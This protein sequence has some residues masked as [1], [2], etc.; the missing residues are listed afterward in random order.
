M[1]VLSSDAQAANRSE[2]SAMAFSRARVSIST[3]TTLHM[4]KKMVKK[5]EDKKKDKDKKKDQDKK[6]DENKNKNQVKKDKVNILK[7]KEN[8]KKDKDH[9]Q[10]EAL[11]S[12]SRKG[13]HCVVGVRQASP[14][15]SAAYISTR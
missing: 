2:L 14:S 15:A 1:R 9:G 13:A 3:S 4:D 10:R 8:I 12:E 11:A 5:N 6:K 7:D